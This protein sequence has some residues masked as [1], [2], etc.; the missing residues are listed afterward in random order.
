MFSLDFVDKE[1][2]KHEAKKR[3]EQG[4]ADSGEY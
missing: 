4:L 2:A 1:K 3:A